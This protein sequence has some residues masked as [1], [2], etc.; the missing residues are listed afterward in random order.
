MEK[1]GILVEENGRTLKRVKF[2]RNL[3]P[4]ACYVFKIK[5]DESIL[6]RNSKKYNISI[7]SDDKLNIDF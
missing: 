2:A 5:N 4:Q 3:Q 6:K 7:T 1:K